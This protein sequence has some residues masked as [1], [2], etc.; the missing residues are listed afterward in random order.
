MH[1]GPRSFQETPELWGCLRVVLSILSH[2]DGLAATHKSKSRP[3]S[4]NLCLPCQ[5]PSVH[6]WFI[7]LLSSVALAGTI[8]SAFG[9]VAEVLK[10]RRR[11]VLERR[12]MTNYGWMD[13]S[14]LIQEKGER[15]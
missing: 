15:Q 2:S 4:A 7:I 8:L 12:M 13:R 3:A 1:C 14:Q 6:P 11:H 9:R 5:A 10:D